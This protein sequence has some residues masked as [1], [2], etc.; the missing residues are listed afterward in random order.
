LLIQGQ[1]Q[2]K[3]LLVIVIELAP[4]KEANKVL[5]FEGSFH[6]RMM[7]TLAATWNKS[8]REPFEWK[9][10]LAEYVKYPQLP[11]SNIHQPFPE[12]WKKFGMKLR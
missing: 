11:D 3:Q 6:G 8:K 5:A 4:H 12:E 10:Y 9:D 7:I 2:M 1:K